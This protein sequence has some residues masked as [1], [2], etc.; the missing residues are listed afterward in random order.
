MM[1]EARMREMQI[2]QSLSCY[3]DNEKKKKTLSGIPRPI[4][5]KSKVTKYIQ[6]LPQKHIEASKKPCIIW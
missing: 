2:K 1:L 5:E 3:H 6:F 4:K